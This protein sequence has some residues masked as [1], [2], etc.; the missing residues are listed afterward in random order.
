MGVTTATTAS[1]LTREW[2][3]A[4]VVTFSLARVSFRDCSRAVCSS[5][6]ALGVTAATGGGGAFRDASPDKGG[7]ESAPTHLET[8]R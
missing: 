6:W 2:G 5:S 8:S 7:A 4:P 1:R 3:G